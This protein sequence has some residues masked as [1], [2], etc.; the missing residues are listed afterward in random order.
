M[1]VTATTLTTHRA[2]SL[3]RTTTVVGL[4]AAAAT[5]AVAAAVHAAGVPLDANGHIP[6]LAFAQM[7]ILGAIIGGVLAA[8]L[9]SHAPGRRFIQVAAAMVA[10][11]CV[12]SLTLPSH[13]ATTLALVTTHLIAAG[14]IVP[15]LA[16]QLDN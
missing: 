9:S 2:S 3:P 4:V 16:R 1:S 7:T 12:P 15:V 8:I 14:I 5:T 6:I 13:V 11:S 10:L